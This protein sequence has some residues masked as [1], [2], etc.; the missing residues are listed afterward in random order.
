[1]TEIFNRRDK[2]VV[3]KKLRNNRPEPEI[4]LW[5]YLR[6]KQ[7][8]F[9]FRRQV[10]IGNFVVDFYCPKIKLVIE[11][12][13]DSHFNKSAKLTDQERQKYLESLGLNVLRFTNNEVVENIEGVIKKIILSIETT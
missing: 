1:M 11:V 3:R 13:G 9:R 10:S 6:N 8:G 12:D 7:L 5:H 2:T 4:K